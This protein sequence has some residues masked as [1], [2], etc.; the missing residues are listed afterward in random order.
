MKRRKKITCFLLLIFLTATSLVFTSLYNTNSR[1]IVF[2]KKP[3]REGR[4]N[5]INN[6][7]LDSSNNEKHETISI[8]YRLSADIDYHYEFRFEFNP[9][10]K[11]DDHRLMLIFYGTKRSCN[12]R[13]IHN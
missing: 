10:T 4:R 12:D 11:N 2:N 7:V 5:S 6:R 13:I 9:S 1:E 3:N 8:Y